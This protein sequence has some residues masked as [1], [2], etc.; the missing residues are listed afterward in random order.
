M[1]QHRPTVLT[2]TAIVQ[3]SPTNSTKLQYYALDFIHES[4]VTRKHTKRLVNTVHSELLLYAEA[5]SIAEQGRVAAW[6]YWT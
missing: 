1:H 6:P 4:K 3:K 5:S 2:A